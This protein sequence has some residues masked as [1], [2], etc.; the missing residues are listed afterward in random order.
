MQKFVKSYLDEL[1]KRHKR[2]KRAAVA[3]L[4][5][6]VLVV[7]GVLGTLA[8]YGVAMEEPEKKPLCGLEEHTHTEEC[9]QDVVICGY[10]KE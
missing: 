7:G 8:Q 6:A 9:Y 1:N 3:L 10:E 5:L 2:N 4:L